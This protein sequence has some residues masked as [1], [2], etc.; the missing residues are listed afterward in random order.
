MHGSRADMK[1]CPVKDCKRCPSDGISCAVN[2]KTKNFSDSAAAQHMKR[3]HPKQP[4]RTQAEWKRYL[5]TFPP[6]PSLAPEPACK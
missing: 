2:E 6:A 5:Q 3:F 4:R 1:M